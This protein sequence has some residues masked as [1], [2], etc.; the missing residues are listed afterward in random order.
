MLPMNRV[1]QVRER[2]KAHKGRYPRIAEEAKLTKPWITR[3]VRGEFPNAGVLTIE[4]LE[5]WLDE[6]D[7][8]EAGEE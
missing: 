7:E 8:R 3:F 6:W 1:E 5:T 2:L 4:R